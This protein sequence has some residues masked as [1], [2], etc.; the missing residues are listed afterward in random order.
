[1]PA[2]FL[3]REWESPWLPPGPSASWRPTAGDCGS[4]AW[5]FDI[6]QSLEAREFDFT[7]AF[8]GFPMGL[9]VPST[10]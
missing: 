6:C 1:M 5:I 4:C 8:C 10:S 9:E 3:S 7:L 2:Q